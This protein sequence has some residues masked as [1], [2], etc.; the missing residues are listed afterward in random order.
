M[1]DNRDTVAVPVVNI[2]IQFENKNPR[3]KE[4]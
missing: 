2:Y 4:P 1:L 3:V